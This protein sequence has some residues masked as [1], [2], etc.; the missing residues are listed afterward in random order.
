MRGVFLSM[1][2][3]GGQFRGRSLN[4]PK[5]NSV[6]PTTDKVRQAIFNA[7]NSRG[8]IAGAVVLDL[9]CGTGALGLE[10]LSRGAARCTFIDNSPPSIKACKA[11]IQ[12]L[13]VQAQCEVVVKDVRTLS[14]NR[15][16]KSTLLLLDPPYRQN[17]VFP[18]LEILAANS[19]L[20]DGAGVV[21]DCEKGAEERLPPGF[22][23]LD[24]KTYGDIKVLLAQYTGVNKSEHP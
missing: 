9:F 5:G 14:Y 13:N 21:V 24:V 3:A 4:V 7:L 2:I 11:N 12:S 19:W 8:W 1:R 18:A 15:G 6:R 10:A 22:T 16:E 17:L 20:A 23:L